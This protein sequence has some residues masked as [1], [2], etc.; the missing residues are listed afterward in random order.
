LTRAPAVE[1]P[2]ERYV[3]A[4]ALSPVAVATLESFDALTDVLWSQWASA[5]ARAAW[6][7]GVETWR[8]GVVGLARSLPIAPGGRSTLP[9]ETTMRRRAPS[10]LLAAPFD[11][12]RMVGTILRALGR[13]HFHDLPTVRQGWAS[14][15]ALAEWIAQFDDLANAMRAAATLA[16]VVTPA[17]AERAHL[18]DNMRKNVEVG[19]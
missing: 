8:R 4:Q 9:A 15:A 19:G 1:R 11:R 7:E 13:S 3:D 17:P 6:L 10:P 5:E 12:Q 18:L 14:A 2:I 16:P